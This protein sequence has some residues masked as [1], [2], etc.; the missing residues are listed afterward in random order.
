MKL[1]RHIV[2]QIYK[3]AMEEYPFECCGIIT[4]NSDKQTLHLCRNIQK[5]LHEEDP[6]RYPRDARIAYM[7]DR[8]EFNRTVSDAKE[9][10][11]EVIAFYHSHP[12]HG[13]Y[14]S[15]EDH[16]A[17][18]VF[19]EPEFPEALHLVV[20]VISRTVRDMKCFKWDG[21]VKAFRVVDC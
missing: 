15:E 20:S 3:H 12:E 18:T 16:A 11:E 6:S 9:K 4:G 7:I 1:D 21:S 8:G 19:G 14:F 13:A 10:G 17:Q 5:S 2:E